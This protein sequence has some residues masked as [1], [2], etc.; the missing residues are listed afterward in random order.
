MIWIIFPLLAMAALLLVLVPL[1]RR[2]PADD[3]DG[4]LAVYRD[5][6]AELDRDLAAGRVAAAEANTARLEIQRRLLAA[7][8]TA[9]AEGGWSGGRTVI[10]PLAAL[11]L[12]GPLG[13]YL[14][15]GRPGL[16]DQPI[17]ARQQETGPMRDLDAAIAAFRT[18]LAQDAQDHGALARLGQALALRGQDAEA[19]DRLKQA[20]LALPLRADLA[21]LLG[22]LLVRQAGGLVTAEAQEAFRAALAADPSDYRARFHLALS[23]EQAG[24]A[25]AALDEYA[26][27]MAMA[28]QGAG[29]LPK[30][31][32]QATALAKKL[33]RPVPQP[34]GRGPEGGAMAAMASLP[35]AERAQAIRSMVDSLAV[36]LETLPADIDGWQRLARARAVLGDRDGAMEALRM[37]A[38]KAPG[39]ADAQL[40][41]ARALLPAEAVAGGMPAEAM[42]LYRKVLALDPD[43][44]EALWFVGQ[45]E[46]EAGNRVAAIR[47]WKRLADQMPQDAPERQSVLKALAGLGE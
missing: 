31:T 17:A 34:G 2:P 32:E 40:A 46:A 15:L 18:R 19:I 35:E 3:R 12:A 45:S 29:W 1:V 41:L 33:G 38:E 8:R 30:V 37:A 9:P 23:Q 22:D 42:T 7:D 43:Q 44:P 14:L 13:A 47:L 26:T 24:E 28:P 25:A 10:V 16:P 27:L 11:L 4:R 5:Q 36:R 20:R 21:S 6:L 39:R